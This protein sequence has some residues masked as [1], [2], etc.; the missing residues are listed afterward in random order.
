MENRDYYIKLLD[1]AYMMSTKPSRKLLKEGTIIDES[2]SVK[3]NREQVIAENHKYYD[4]VKHL[5]DIQNK[6][7][8]EVE[9][10]I[11]N[12]YIVDS[13]DHTLN[14]EARV[15][16]FTEAYM[17]GHSEGANEIFSQLDELICFVNDLL[18]KM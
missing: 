7:A 9:D 15:Y 11:I 17:L 5:K 18:N 10:K 16:I 4:E 13:L 14:Y 3:W 1:S 2:K 6:K 12:E 8:V